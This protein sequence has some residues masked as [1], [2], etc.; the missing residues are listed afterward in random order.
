[1]LHSIL[2]KLSGFLPQNSFDYSIVEVLAAYFLLVTLCMNFLFNLLLTKLSGP[3]FLGALIFVDQH[4]LDK[5]SFHQNIFWT[6]D[7]FLQ[8]YCLFD[9]NIF[10]NRNFLCTTNFLD[11]NIFYFN[12]SGP[13]FLVPR[14][15]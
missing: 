6:K 9:Q 5:T 1:M 4:F 2:W 12:F 14:I 11:L 10:C 8:I 7:F 15:F 3:N 13:Y